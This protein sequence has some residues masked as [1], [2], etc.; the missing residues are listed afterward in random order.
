MLH[1]DEEL[2]HILID[3]DAVSCYTESH[4]TE[5]GHH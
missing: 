3:S 2:K 4:D 5:Y 1:V